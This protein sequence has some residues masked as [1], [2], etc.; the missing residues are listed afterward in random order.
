MVEYTKLEH[1]INL[2]GKHKG[3]FEDCPE[4]KRKRDEIKG[5]EKRK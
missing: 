4:C 2:S 5:M 1:Q 3:K